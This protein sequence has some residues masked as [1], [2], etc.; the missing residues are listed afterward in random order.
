LDDDESPD[1]DSLQERFG[2]FLDIWVEISANEVEEF[3]DTNEED[4]DEMISF[5]IEDITHLALDSAAKWDLRSFLNK[6]QLP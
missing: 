1:S 2:E 6:L 3:A 4:N 5:T